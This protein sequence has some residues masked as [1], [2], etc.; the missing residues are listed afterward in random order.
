MWRRPLSSNA[1]F[2]SRVVLAV[3][4]GTA[5]KLV[6]LCQCT[7][8]VR[9][10]HHSC[11]RRWVSTKAQSLARTTDPSSA[12]DAAQTCELCTT[13]YSIP[14]KK[15]ELP[16][17]DDEK[18]ARRLCWLAA[19]CICFAPCIAHYSWLKNWRSDNMIVF[20]FM[21]KTQQIGLCFVY[22]VLFLLVGILVASV[23]A[24]GTCAV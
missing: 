8:S 15:I 19:V 18:V 1:R 9:W 20:G 10:Q 17:D 6:S 14:V 12:I 21:L 3:A 5:E 23:V 16:E 2:V 24:A 22:A 4:D 11:L 7:G 13:S